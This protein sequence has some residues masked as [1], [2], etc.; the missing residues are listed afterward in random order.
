M[1]QTGRAIE[2]VLDDVLGGHGAGR[3][4]AR[5]QEAVGLLVVPHAD[6]AEGVDHALREQDVVGVHQVFDQRCGRS[7]EFSGHGIKRCAKGR[8]GRNGK[9]TAASGAF[10]NQACQRP[11]GW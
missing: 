3:H 9:H 6:V 7:D 4:V 2:F 10:N 1:W 5:Q 11:P 8:M